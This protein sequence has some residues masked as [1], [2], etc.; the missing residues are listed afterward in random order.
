MEERHIE[1][2]ELSLYEIL[3]IVLKYKKQVIKILVIGFILSFGLAVGLKDYNRK[4]LGKQEFSVNYDQF[5]KKLE[6]YE[7]NGIS[8][9]KF[10][11]QIIVQSEEY[12]DKFLEIKELKESFS[13]IKVTPINRV[14][15]KVKFISK[16]IKVEQD[17]EKPENYKLSIIA[18]K[19]AN[20]TEKIAEI[21][22]EILDN[23]VVGKLDSIVKK[24][25]SNSIKLN[26]EIST[27]LEEI[28]KQTVVLAEK[29]ARKTNTS[30]ENL[31]YLVKMKEPLLMSEKDFQQSL[32]ERTSKE[33]SG[34]DQIIASKTLDNIIQKNSSLIITD[35]DGLA[36][37]IL[38][39]G[40]VFSF[41]IAIGYIMFKEF[42]INYEKY[43]KESLIE[44]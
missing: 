15:E 27:K 35:K 34:I 2:E 41:L 25:Q 4:E 7:I 14:E 20:I 40:V 36:K 19:K 11:P 9:K 29:E 6:Y 28:K 18:L 39:A 24:E 33:I 30:A 38:L 17:K 22:F 1:E 8:Y 12:I 21:Y 5:D 23:E 26:K 3:E 32:Y 43:R 10:N 13:K 44:K 16:R 37:K 31:D 42:M